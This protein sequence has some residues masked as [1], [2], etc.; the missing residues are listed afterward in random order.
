MGSGASNLTLSSDI[1][2]QLKVQAEKPND[3]SDTTNYIDEII[4]IRTLLSTSGLEKINGFQC[5]FE[6]PIDGSDIQTDDDAKAE[7]ISIRINLK[8]L[9]IQS[10]PPQPTKTDN[11]IKSTIDHSEMDTHATKNVPT[12][13][14]IKQL[15][16]YLITPF[17]GDEYKIARV[18]YRWITDNIKYDRK[19]AIKKAGEKKLK[20]FDLQCASRCCI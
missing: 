7:L 9:F 4:Q 10:L 16:D 13:K 3:V 5:E 14:K 1:L 6:K 15:V 8:K 17:K 12:F 11:N 18:I 2:S 20:T 19:V